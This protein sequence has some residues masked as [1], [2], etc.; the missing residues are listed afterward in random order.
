[1]PPI[2]ILYKGGRLPSWHSLSRDDQKAHEQEHVDL[3][4]SIA[5][6]HRMMRLEGFRLMA[7]QG[8]YE[9]FWLI[10][11]PELESAEAWINAEMA[12]PYGTYG[13]YE[14]DL[15]RD[16]QPSYCRD[17]VV[18]ETPRVE[19]LTDD[20]HQVPPLSVDESSVVVLNFERN[21]PGVDLEASPTD[22][23]LDAMRSVAHDHGL[24]RLECF[25]LVTPKADWHRVWLA[26]FPTVE[27]AEAWV[28]TEVSPTHGRK[29]QRVFQLSRK[30]APR[31]FASW[32]PKG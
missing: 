13:D 4:L 3:M 20:P 8:A 14:Y 16:V 18:S 32:I 5:R 31:Y 28:N 17:W 27:G 9:R 22:P 11:F 12:P 19:P 24:M 23:Y 21:E 6:Q 1:M 2:T 15:A 25:A 30:W 10:E 26:E 7:P 29:A